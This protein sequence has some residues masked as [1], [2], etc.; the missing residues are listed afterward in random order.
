MCQLSCGEFGLVDPGRELSVDVVEGSFERGV[1]GAMAWERGGE[2]WTEQ[3][4]VEAGEEEGDAEAVFSDAISK[5]PGQAFD[6]AMEAETA[7]LVGDGALADCF[8]ET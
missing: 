3:A 5:T 4:I 8:G 1:V 2:A 6:H 7:K